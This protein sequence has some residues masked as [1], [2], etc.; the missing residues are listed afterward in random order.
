MLR[1]GRGRFRLMQ[2]HKEAASLSQLV[3]AAFVAGLMLLG[4]GSLVSNLGRV[5]L[6]VVLLAYA[7]L[8]LGFSAAL[9]FRRGWRS[10]LVAPSIYLTIHLGFGVGYWAEA[11]QV[12]REKLR[13]EKI[14]SQAA[15][16]S[17]SLAGPTGREKTVP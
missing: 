8:L 3:P 17:Q 12:F 14:S 9:G 13:S 10:F 16:P 15:G 1:Y 6:L 4:A 11:L 2:K 7:A 5:S